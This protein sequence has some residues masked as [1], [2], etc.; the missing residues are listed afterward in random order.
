[1]NA[2]IHHPGDLAIGRDHRAGPKA[3]VG[4]SGKVIGIET[5]TQEEGLLE[6][7]ATE[8]VIEVMAEIE[9][10]EDTEI[11]IETGTGTETEI[12]TRI[13]KRGRSQKPNLPRQLQVA[14]K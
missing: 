10:I 14:K 1:M 8:I 9:G 6:V 5:A 4:S 3:L 12:A 2:E 13:A 7:T 11:A